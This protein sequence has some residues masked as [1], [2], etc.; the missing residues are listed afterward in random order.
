MINFPAY[1]ILGA[2]ATA[3]LYAIGFLLLSLLGWWEERGNRAYRKKILEENKR[4]F[5]K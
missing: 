3:A 5:P 2:V 1:F 4:L